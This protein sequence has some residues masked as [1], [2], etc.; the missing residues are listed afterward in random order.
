MNWETMVGVVVVVDATVV[1][2]VV[3]VVDVEK[4]S[5]GRSEL[6]SE[7]ADGVAPRSR[8]HGGSALLVVAEDEAEAEGSHV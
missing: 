3:V 5:V 2:T 8:S 4:V 1:V 6:G 7:T